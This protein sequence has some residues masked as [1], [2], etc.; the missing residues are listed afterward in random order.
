VSLVLSTQ[1]PVWLPDRPSRAFSRAI[2]LSIFP[3]ISLLDCCQ[4]GFRWYK[5][6]RV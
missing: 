5:R 4:C 1:E 3:D 6:G 2:V